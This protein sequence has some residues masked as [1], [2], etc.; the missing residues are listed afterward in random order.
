MNYWLVKSDPDEYGWKELVRDQSTEWTGVRNFTAR[1]NLKSMKSG[2]KVLF[3]HSQKEKAVVGISKVKKEYHP[4]STAAKGEPWVAVDLAPIKALK[5][6]VTLQR[7]KA[8][9]RLSHIH[10]VRQARLSV[11]PLGEKEFE[12]ILG[13]GDEF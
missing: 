2:D 9:K 7:I 3:Y 5:T 8:E 13:M 1:N 6:S 10:L 12:M 11:M 4:D